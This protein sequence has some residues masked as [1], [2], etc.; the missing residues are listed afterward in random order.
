MRDL[1][2]TNDGLAGHIGRINVA[3]H[4]SVSSPCFKGRRE[5]AGRLELDPCDAMLRRQVTFCYEQLQKDLDVLHEQLH[6]EISAAVK[7]EV[8][9]IE[10]QVKDS[11]REEAVEMGELFEHS[12]GP[13]REGLAQLRGE[14][15]KHSQELQ[16]SQQARQKQQGAQAMGTL[17]VQEAAYEAAQDAVR[18]TLDSSLHEALAEATQ[19]AVREATQAA[20]TAAAE[21]AAQVAEEWREAVDAIQGRNRAVGERLA[22]LEQAEQRLTSDLKAVCGEQSGLKLKGSLDELKE[23]M[24]DL[25]D[26]VEEAV[27]ELQRVWEQSQ[28]SV[29]EVRKEYK[30]S[31]EEFRKEIQDS[32]KEVR[33]EIQDS[34]QEVRQKMQDAAGLLEGACEDIRQEVEGLQTQLLGEVSAREAQHMQTAQATGSIIAAL[35]QRVVELG[36]SVAEGANAS[37]GADLQ[38]RVDEVLHATNE[39]LDDL[40]RE[41]VDIG[42]QCQEGLC[43]AQ[44]CCAKS[45]EWRP[46]VDAELLEQLGM[47]SAESPT[48][49]CAGVAGLRLRLLITPSAGQVGFAKSWNCGAFLQAPD[50]RLAFRLAVVGSAAQSLSGT[51]SASVPEVGSQRIATLDP[52]ELE[53]LALRF[54]MLDVAEAPAIGTWPRDLGAF[55]QMSDP[56]HAAQREVAALRSSMVRRV[57]WRMTRV[58][59]RVKRARAAVS[60][61]GDEAFEPVLSPTFAAAGVENLQLQMYP[62]GYRT[63]SDESCGFFLVCPRGVYLKVKAFVGNTSRVF[64]HTYTTREPFGRGSFCRLEDKVDEDGCVICGIEILEVRQDFVTQAKG[65]SPSGMVDQLKVS[66]SPGGPCGMEVVRELCDEPFGGEKRGKAPGRP[67]KGIQPRDLGIT[68]SPMA[69]SKS[70]PVLQTVGAGKQKAYALGHVHAVPPGLK[71]YAA[72]LPKIA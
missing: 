11:K 72:A 7:H 19:R 71:A 53:G 10:H 17:E 38:A 59:D 66:R 6:R 24:E 28:D 9:T 45:I 30:D 64:E 41:V 43:I 8:G 5:K 57:E 39:R 69:V 13:L 3:R 1:D 58:L 60:I 63:R 62:V 22:T 25:K 35:E 52:D 4:P 49:A 56:Q 46:A 67:K 33:R 36:Q 37:Q 42:N 15:E 16:D 65:A 68:D 31:L 2:T 40:Q 55:V 12:L 48:F 44:S 18:E 50:G 23:S 54:D 26:S 51:F 47:F 27:E 29:E 61:D 32:T 21:A 14:V 34:G 70:L 20:E